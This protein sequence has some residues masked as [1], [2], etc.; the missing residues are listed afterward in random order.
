[1]RWS[2]GL[3]G[4]TMQKWCFCFTSRGVACNPVP[5]D[6]AW[7]GTANRARGLLS[8]SA[9]DGRPNVEST[10]SP[11]NRDGHVEPNHAL[12]TMAGL[13]YLTVGAPTC[14]MMPN[15]SARSSSSTRSTPA[16][17]KAPRPQM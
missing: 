9:G 10:V 13:R 12:R 16:W 15:N 8:T 5:R 1:M 4:R 17:P 11:G 14:C 7:A 3:R 6:V 2:S